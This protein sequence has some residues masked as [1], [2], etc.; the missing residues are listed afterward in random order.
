LERRLTTINATVIVDRSR[1]DKMV[2]DTLRHL[3]ELSAPDV[4]VTST[5]SQLGNVA[6]I[7]LSYSDWPG[8]CVFAHAYE[9]WI[10]TGM[11]FE[12]RGPF[13]IE[14]LVHAANDVAAALDYELELMTDYG[15]SCDFRSAPSTTSDPRETPPV[16]PYFHGECA[17]V[18][19]SQLTDW[20]GTL[21]E[22]VIR[23]LAAHSTGPRPKSLFSINPLPRSPQAFAQQFVRIINSISPVEAAWKVQTDHPSIE[24]YILIHERWATE[25][26]LSSLVG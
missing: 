8:Q 4:I 16:A 25:L 22:A 18:P 23:W 26:S 3:A 15:S 6:Y 9:P 12:I 13:D 5:K 24:H 11:V 1:G 17:S 7:E 20:Q 21:A 19:K 10:E 14:L 2:E